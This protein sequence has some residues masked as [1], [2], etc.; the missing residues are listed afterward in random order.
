M[1]TPEE[2]R[3]PWH[4]NVT[5]WVILL[6]AIVTCTL[7]WLA[8]GQPGVPLKD[9]D[10]GCYTPFQ[11]GPR[12]PGPGVTVVEG[13][14]VDV[15]DFDLDSGT[16]NSVPHSDFQRVDPRSFTIASVSVS[17]WGGSSHEYECTI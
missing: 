2:Y 15:W 4:L 8:A 10:Y 16:R 13:Q 12:I 17:T 6:G 3:I 5:N 9:G 14:I 1:S 11:G 7:G